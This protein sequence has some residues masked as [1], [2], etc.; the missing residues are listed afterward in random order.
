MKIYSIKYEEST[1]EL[2]VLME[3]DSIKIYQNVPKEVYE[4]FVKEESKE[5]FISENLSSY[6][7]K[8]SKMLYS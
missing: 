1:K 5:K 7:V 2:S 8:S 4:S 3:G 6:S